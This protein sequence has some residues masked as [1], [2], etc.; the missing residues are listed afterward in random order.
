MRAA[1]SLKGAAR[2]VEIHPGVTIAHAMEDLFVLHLADDAA[3]RGLK[4]GESPP[5]GLATRTL[6]EV[7]DDAAGSA[8]PEGAA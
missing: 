8:A 3:I 1:H 5:P 7:A 6:A 2:I 4:F